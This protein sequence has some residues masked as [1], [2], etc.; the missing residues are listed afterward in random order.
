MPSSYAAARASRQDQHLQD[1]A[2]YSPTRNVP[3]PAY[4]NVQRT[5]GDAGFRDARPAERLNDPRLGFKGASPLLANARATAQSPSALPPPP[6]PITAFFENAEEEQAAPQPAGRR[7]D[8]ALVR[9]EAGGEE[10]GQA[11]LPPPPPPP[12]SSADLLQELEGAEDEEPLPPLPTSGGSGELPP[13][14][15]KRT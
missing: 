7:Q 13:Y 6:N 5:A 12:K 10:G 11:P 4:T 8:N 15:G 14:S 1:D 3:S 2:P 9:K